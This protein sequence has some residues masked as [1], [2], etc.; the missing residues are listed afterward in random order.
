MDKRTTPLTPR[1]RELLS[2]ALASI[3]NQPDSY[4][5]M[6]YGTGRID[7][8][9]PACVA[10]HIVAADRQ[11][12][13]A[14]SEALKTQLLPDCEWQH[15]RRIAREGLNLD[16]S[17]AVFASWWPTDWCTRANTPRPERNANESWMVPEVA[18]AI[19]VLTAVL[20]GRITDALAP[21]NV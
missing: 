8:N 4:E 13:N 6:K 1:Q 12:R 16:N 19:A 5:Q 21:D 7:C 14:L 10:G 2:Q 17:P 20:D 3:S 11:C 9:S 18:T 15:I